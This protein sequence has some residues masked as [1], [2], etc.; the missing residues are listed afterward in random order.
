MRPQTNRFEAYEI[1]LEIICHLRELLP[2]I[3]KHDRDLEKQGR[4]AA[5]SMALNLKEGN[6]RLGRDRIHQFSIA[7]GSADEV[8]GVL[9][10]SEAWGYLQAD[11][12]K[13]ARELLDRELAM[14]WRLTHPAG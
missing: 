14:T 12:A 3:K 7:A 1:A 4:R 11:L 10:V 5:S 6:R 13:P 2:R 9:D 8:L